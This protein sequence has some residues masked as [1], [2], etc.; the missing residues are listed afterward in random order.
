MNTRTYFVSVDSRDRDRL[1]WTKSSK[2]EVKMDP[3]PGFT[4]AAIQR[5][6]KNVVSIEL[7]DA[8]FPFSSSCSYMYL[9]LYEV[10][11]N[12]LSTHN[13]NQY[14]TKIIPKTVLNGFVYGDPDN[15]AH[16]K[17][18]LSRGT[19][20]DKLTIELIQPNGDTADFGEDTI[21]PQDPIPSIQTSFSFKIVVEDMQ[22]E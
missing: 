12:I 1:V 16:K 9:K 13:G 4:G 21:P 7:L 3:L 14:F 10:D 18:F 5:S 2:F 17:V 8:V 19:R 20:I 6:F 11:G 15:D 22:R